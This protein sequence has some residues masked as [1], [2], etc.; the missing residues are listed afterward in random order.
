ML[1]K[2]LLCLL[3]TA[4]SAFAQ[5]EPQPIQK[6]EME[7]FLFSL[8]EV[9]KGAYAPANWKKDL[10]EWDIEE[11]FSKAKTSLH[12]LEFA[13]LKDFQSILNH[14]LDSFED[15]HVGAFFHSTE[16]SFLPFSVKTV[17]GRTFVV[18]IDSFFI[19]M[20]PLRVGDEIIT[21]GG[22][23]I[24]QVLEELRRTNRSG[25]NE[26]TNVGLADMAL[27]YRRGERVNPMA[28]GCVEI[29]F[30][31]KGLRGLKKAAFEWE[32]FSEKITDPNRITK[33]LESKKYRK[34]IPDF[35]MPYL[36]AK[37]P[38]LDRWGIGDRDGFLPHL[39]FV[40]WETDPES[41]YRA[42][43]YRNQE[44]KR[45]GCIRIPHFHKWDIDELAEIVKKME[46]ETDGL[47][48]DQINNSGGLFFY[49]YGALSLFITEPINALHEQ[50]RIDQQIVADA[51]LYQ[52]EVEIFGVE[53]ALGD[54]IDGYTVTPKVAEG[55][56][57][58]GEFMQSQWNSGK[59]LTDPFP[60]LGIFEVEPHPAVRYTK[61]ILVLVNELDFS[62]GDFF[63]ALLQD[64][65]RAKIMGTKTAGAGGYVET[66]SFPNKFGM[67]DFA[68]TR[69][70]AYRANGN[71][72]EN[73]GVV[74]DIPYE[75]SVEDL[76]NNY[77]P[78][79]DAINQALRTM[80]K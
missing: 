20:N 68:I 33:S 58:Y 40:I 23:P 80:L 34:L 38:R 14:F 1:K 63:P 72:L 29:E 78:Y 9:Y 48:I 42:Y 54:E 2:V 71:P 43:I 4:F 19:D 35:R 24:Q 49:L 52:E 22:R 79:T 57:L 27:T 30:K 16:S 73:L 61:P 55:F 28:A 37:P 44:G 21:F 67:S 31:R 25:C 5:G 70:V 47:V 8:K 12:A 45:I 13:T 65:K 50:T 56:I 59:F 36:E 60:L 41:E 15:Y 26:K 10:Y 7:N 74:P 75:I 53:W 46:S 6:E 51:I 18:D 76:Q 69:S 66:Y 64:S 3:F 32:Y 62:C 17:E 11:E 39:G 77:K